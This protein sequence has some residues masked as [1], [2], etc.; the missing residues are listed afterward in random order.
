MPVHVDIPRHDIPVARETSSRPCD[1]SP[2]VTTRPTKARYCTVLFVLQGPCY[3][4]VDQD[5]T[6]TVTA[7]CKAG[8][9][10]INVKTNQSFY[11]K[12][13]TQHQDTICATFYLLL[14]FQL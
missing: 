7:T 10:T 2:S 11:G 14:I 8:Y 5:F 13:L 12:Y 4:L 9:M 1:S 3:A 6:P